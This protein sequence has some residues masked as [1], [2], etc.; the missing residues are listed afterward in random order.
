MPEVATLTTSSAQDYT[1]VQAVLRAA[2]RQVFGNAHLMEEQRV[3]IAESLFLQG[4]LTVQGLI[5]AL[6]N[7]DTYRRLF[8]EKNGPYRFVELNFKHLLGRAPRD[9]VEVSEH[10]QLLAADG[11]ETEIA[12]YILSEEY[13]SAFGFDTVPHW[14][15][16]RTQPGETNLTYVRSLK[17]KGGMASFDGATASKLQ[18]SIATGVAPRVVLQGGQ[19]GNSSR[20][21]R[22]Y[23]VSWTTASPTGGNRRVAQVSIVPFSSLTVTLQSIQRR[24]GSIL[25]VTNS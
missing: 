6:A 12:S 16:T 18:S 13:I 8:L 20:N 15:S 5:S 4:D 22:R 7:S 2:Y 10:V 17:L 11:Y 9:Q 23:R 1:H 21:D 24:G 19:I 14:R 25:S 3:S